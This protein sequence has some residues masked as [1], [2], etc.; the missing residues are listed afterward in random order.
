MTSIGVNLSYHNSGNLWEVF[1][2]KIGFVPRQLPI[3]PKASDKTV[4]TSRKIGICAKYSLTTAPQS[5]TANDAPTGLGDL[6]IY[7]AANNSGVAHI[8]L[9]SISIYRCSAYTNNTTFTWTLW[10]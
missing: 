7:F 2:R 3:T 6:C 8:P 5:N 9:T 4:A 1:C 10:F